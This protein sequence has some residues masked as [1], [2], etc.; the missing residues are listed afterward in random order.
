MKDSQTATGEVSS[1][2]LAD[3]KVVRLEGAL[4]SV[5]AGAAGDGEVEGA[6]GR[7]EVVFG[8]S[9]DSSPVWG[10]LESGSVPVHPL[11]HTSKPTTMNAAKRC[12]RLEIER[13]L[14]V[15][16][17]GIDMESSFRGL[18]CR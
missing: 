1:M 11:R 16:E 9:F 6:S 12:V 17:T 10:S 5:I 18:F 14:S 13:V 4:V 8:S 15:P 2:F 3:A 7:T